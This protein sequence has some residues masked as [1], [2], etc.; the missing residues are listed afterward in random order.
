MELQVL[1]PGFGAKVRGIGNGAGA[2]RGV[3]NV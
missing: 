1:G 2:E 3:A